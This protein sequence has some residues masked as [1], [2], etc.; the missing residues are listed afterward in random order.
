MRTTRRRIVAL[1]LSL[2]ACA[3]DSGPTDP[4]GIPTAD[5][6]AWSDPTTWPGGVVP[7]QGDSVVI[8]EG[9]TVRLDV[10]PPA[11]QSLTINGALV[12]GNTD[13]TLTAGWIVVVGALQAGT[14]VAP[15]THRALI[16][17]TGTGTPT[18]PDVFGMGNKVLGVGGRI[19]LHGHAR[20]GWTHLSQTA[21][22]G[23][24]SIELVSNPG[25]KAGDRL[26][27]ASSDYSPDKT[28]EVVVASVSGRT[29]TLA[30]PLKYEHYGQVVTVSGVTVDERAEVGLLTRNITIQGDTGSTPGYGGHIIVLQGATA[31]IEGVELFQMGQ[32][33]QLARYP[34]HWHMAGDVSGQYFRNNS[35]WRTFN[36]CV[37]VHGSD[38]SVVENNV[39][40]D[41]TGHGY[42]LEDGAETGNLIQGNLGLSSR[43]PSGTD[44]LLGSDSR[45]A[46]FWI[47]NPDNTFRGNVAAGSRGFGFWCAFPAAPTG[48]SVGQPDL[49]RTTPLREFSGNVAH[50]NNS[51]GLNVDDGP[52]LDGNTET[53][54]YAPRVNPAAQSDP[55]TADF[56][57]FRAYKHSGRAV[58]LRGRN[59]RLS[60]ALLA[61]N[62]IGAT[63]AANETYV[64]N[65]TFIGQSG[66]ITKLPSQTV[67]RGYEF[68]D[69]RVWADGVKFINY[70]AATTVPA[71][72]LG[73]N[74]NNAFPIDPENYAGG[75]TF[76]NANQVYLEDAHADKDGD[77]AAVFLD[78]GGSVTGTAG[79]WVA[80]NTPILLSGACTY[81]QAWNAHVCTNRF[82]NLAVN[83]SASDAIAPL[84]VTRDDAVSLALSGTGNGTTHA[85][86]TGIPGRSYTL[87]WSGATPVNPRFYLNSAVAGD[88]VVLTF[89]YPAAPSKIQRDYWDGN[90][91]TA[92][93]SAAEVASGAGDKYYYDAGAG[94]LTIRLVAMT[95]RDWATLFVRP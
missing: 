20:K 1:A 35:V 68:Y 24:T 53:T 92:A 41:H 36:R 60:N 73:Y 83:T 54:N 11:L 84:T 32:R 62:A 40:Y 95:G 4:G 12:F 19:E 78:Q 86:F 29:V 76:I 49:P 91:V 71:S 8:P 33:G 82:V 81:R 77:K 63:F 17:L 37:T 42:F 38:N 69:G 66:T 13:I 16:T 39:C 80:A 67:L 85:A 25:W 48:L 75:L 64:T 46:T 2:A 87:Q 22:A 7:V 93:A 57:G 10:S 65:T 58:W 31:H 34:M 14:E 47:T 94:T 6:K 9:T 3:R 45:P 30:A 88:G 56:T 26:V 72:A 51:G 89:P 55:V 18:S 70:T 28:D 27:L 61:D 23:A 44:R 15:Y 74:R 21:A 50:S 5:A 90:P 43:V 59:L 79:R 52:M